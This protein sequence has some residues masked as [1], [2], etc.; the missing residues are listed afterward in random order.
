MSAERMRI[1]HVWEGADGAVPIRVEQWRAFP[2]RSRTRLLVHGELVAFADTGF[3]RTMMVRV[4]GESG[5]A[6]GRVEVVAMVRGEAGF[7]AEGL[8]T[9]SCNGRKVVMHVVQT[10][11]FSAQSAWLKLLMLL[12]YVVSA[13]Y[14]E[15]L[16]G[17]QWLEYT[18]LALIVGA[19][20]AADAVPVY[21]TKRS[22]TESA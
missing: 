14:V 7:D 11:W 16:T 19:I 18:M 2:F 21:P 1:R 13:T 20:N 8:C 5:D 12:A 22:I 3:F 15:E 6:D 10:R 9:V 17:Y 4:V